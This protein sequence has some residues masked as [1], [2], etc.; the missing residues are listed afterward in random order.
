MFNILNGEIDFIQSL[1]KL[2]LTS[3]YPVYE[4]D[5]GL[6]LKK[7]WLCVAEDGKYLLIKYESG[8]LSSALC[9]YEDD[10]HSE[11]RAIATSKEVI[12]N[13]L[14]FEQIKEFFE[15]QISEDDHLD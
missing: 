1:I 8:V 12:I 10:L 3:A 2:K 15:F 6:L 9:D 13:K 14:N 11:L 4:N 5:G 7:E